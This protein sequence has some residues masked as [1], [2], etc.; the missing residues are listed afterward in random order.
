MQSSAYFARF[1]LLGLI[2]AVNAFF[3]AA[4]VALLSVRDSRLRHMAEEGHQGAKMALALLANPGR[5][6]SVTQVGVTLASLGLGWAGEDTLYEIL[7]VIFHPILTPATSTVLHAVCFVLAFAVMTYCHVVIGEVVPKNVA[8]EKAGRLAVI[9][10][11]TLTLISKIA[12]PF[13][14][15]IDG[16]SL[17]ITR[18]LG[19]R[20]DHRAGG[21]VGNLKM[22]GY[23]VWARSIGGIASNHLTIDQQP[24][25]PAARGRRD[26]HRHILPNTL[27]QPHGAVLPSIAHPAELCAA[28]RD[29]DRHHQVVAHCRAPDRPPR[30]APVRPSLGR[31]P[32]GRG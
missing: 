15:L 13:V 11:P 27:R 20:S 3:A 17:A 8:I 2:L 31:F 14:N 10:A 18:L 12:S 9:V 29:R 30:R 21:H 25:L 32:Q 4:E 1:L 22:G 26:C 5:W 16:S 24:Q 19:V 23:M 28:R 6:L 7:L